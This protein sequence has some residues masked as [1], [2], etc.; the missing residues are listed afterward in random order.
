[1]VKYINVYTGEDSSMLEEYRN[2]IA[3]R[4]AALSAI[5]D[6]RH[7]ENSISFTVNLADEARPHQLVF[8]SA[9]DQIRLIQADGTE[10]LSLTLAQYQELPADV[11]VINLLTSLGLGSLDAVLQLADGAFNKPR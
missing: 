11:L 5:S 10:K 2:Q 6:I 1:M 7:E 4:L 9:N 3:L 8:D